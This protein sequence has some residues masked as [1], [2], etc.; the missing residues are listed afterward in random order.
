M[1]GKAYE[2]I[3]TLQQILGEHPNCELVYKNDFELLTAIILSA[4]CTD[5]RVNA[6]T[7]LLFA[8]FPTVADMSNAKVTDIED[9]IKP[10][11][12]YHSKAKHL[13]DTA[14]KIMNDF[15]GAVPKTIPELMKLSGVGEKTASVFVAEFYNT[16]AIGVDTHIMRVSRRLGLS[17]S[18]TPPQISRDLQRQLPPT[19]WRDFHILLVLFGR[20]NCTARKPK[21]ENCPLSSQCLFVRPIR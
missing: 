15:H 12:F 3:K 18:K 5:K 8:K 2:I 17:N 14:K 4:Q 13:R 19:Q 7:P 16:P 9:I 1:Q 20:Y 10:C 11:G 21:C 6:T